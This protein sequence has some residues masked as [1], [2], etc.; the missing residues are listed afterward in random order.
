MPMQHPRRRFRR[1]RLSCRLESAVIMLGLWRRRHRT[2]RALR[3]IDAHRLADIGRA[4]A[5][6]R[7]ECAKWF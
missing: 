4:D 3:E 1:Q 6:R 2:R 5:E 7:R